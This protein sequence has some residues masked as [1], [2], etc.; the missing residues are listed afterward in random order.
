MRLFLAILLST[1]ITACYCQ[2]N[3][4]PQ[5]IRIDPTAASGGALSDY[6]SELTFIPLNT[7][8][9]SL[10]QNIIQLECTNSHLFAL[11]K[12]SNILWILN[13]DGSFSGSIEVDIGTMQFMVDD[14]RK[15]IILKKGTGAKFYSYSGTPVPPPP[16]IR[17]GKSMYGV[18]GITLKDNSTIYFNTEY[19]SSD[20]AR[21]EILYNH[22]NGQYSQFFLIE[23]SQKVTS[24]S[25]IGAGSLMATLLDQSRAYYTRIFDYN[26]YSISASK[27][28]TLFKFIFPLEFSIPDDPKDTSFR[29]N[30]MNY[31]KNPLN[32]N[33]ILKILHFFQAGN[34]LLFTAGKESY[35]YDLGNQT[36]TKLSA[37]RPDHLSFHLP[38]VT[39]DRSIAPGSHYIAAFDGYVYTKLDPAF[40]LNEIERSG[41][42]HSKLPESL[43]TTVKKIKRAGTSNPIIIKLKVKS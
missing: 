23:N 16:K 26:V 13:N 33:A 15:L 20:S 11:D 31:L 35:I 17:L 21:Y 34:K 43:Q 28:D 4:S 1:F 39:T 12:K 8:K 40:L 10:I 27:V 25:S 14:V 19:R 38:V 7:P 30:E 24:F 2:E 5:K 6:F 9:N 3:S 42:D 41:I 32:K 36:V 22:P 18:S 29:G 37:L